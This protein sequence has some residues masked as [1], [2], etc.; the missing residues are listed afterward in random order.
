V[1]CPKTQ[2]ANLP[3]LSLSNQICPNLITV[4]L[5]KFRL[6]FAQIS[7]SF[8]PILLQLYHVLFYPHLLYA[9]PM[10]GSTYKTYLQKI[11][12]LQNRAVKTITHTDWKSSPNP[13]Y[14][15][16]NILKLDQLCK[17]EVSN[18]MHSLYFNQHPYNLSQNFTKSKNMHSRNTRSSSMSF[19]AIPFFKTAKLQ[20]SFSYQEVKIWNLIPQDIK[21]TSST[22]FKATYKQYLLTN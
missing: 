21:L 16:L 9:I 15:S 19:F 6:N 17:L 13:S 8:C 14:H 2:Q 12:T 1:P 10:W 4:V 7:P 3:I 20:Q 22:K 5:P 11:S 18:I